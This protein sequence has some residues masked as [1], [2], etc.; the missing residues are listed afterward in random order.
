M[1]NQHEITRDEGLSELVEE[2]LSTQNP[3]VYATGAAT[4]WLEHRVERTLEAVEHRLLT[5][6]DQHINQIIE[7]RLQSLEQKIQQR[8]EQRF[9]QR[10]RERLENSLSTASTGSREMLF[11]DRLQSS[12]IGVPNVATAQIEHNSQTFVSFEHESRLMDQ[13]LSTNSE[14]STAPTVHRLGLT[15]LSTPE[16]VDGVPYRV[17]YGKPNLKRYKLTYAV[18]FSFTDL[19]GTLNEPG[20]LVKNLIMRCVRLWKRGD[21]SARFSAVDQRHPQLLRTVVMR[22]ELFA[23]CFGPANS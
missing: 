14:G 23:G 12:T 9:E 10:F 18:L 11:D 13:Q 21:P 4:E 22:A 1:E 20:K 7:Q 16:G 19:E 5:E 17:K 3:S 6:L 2:R 8:F 15:E